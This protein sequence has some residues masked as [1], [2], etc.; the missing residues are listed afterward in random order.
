MMIDCGTWRGTKEHLAEYVKDLKA[1]VNNEVDLLVITHKHKDHVHSFEA[2][3]E[4]F[5]EDFKIN[6][7]WMGWTEDDKN[8]RVKEWRKH[9]G[10]KKRLCLKQRISLVLR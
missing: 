7:I 5:T 3:R 6:K 4:L 1:Y 9:H 2:C 10:E 8:K